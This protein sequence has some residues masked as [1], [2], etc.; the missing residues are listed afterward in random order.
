M[1][2]PKVDVAIIREQEKRR[3]ENARKERRDL[4]DEISAFMKQKADVCGLSIEEIMK[5]ESLKFCCTEAAALKARYDEEIQAVLDEVKAGNEMTDI[6][7]L[8]EKARAVKNKYE[9]E[10]LKA[11]ESFK[12]Y[13]DKAAVNSL[14]KGEA[15]KLS[16]AGKKKTAVLENE[17]PAAVLTSAAAVTSAAPVTADEL[18]VLFEAFHNEI[19][20]FKAGRSLTAV[21]NDALMLMEYDLKNVLD[22][23]LAP[24]KKKKK[25]AQYGEELQRKIEFIKRDTEEALDLYAEY[26]REC[27]DTAGE[28]KKFGDFSDKGEIKRE[29][30]AVKAKAEAALSKE[31]IRRQIDEVMAE[32][33]YDIIRSDVLSEAQA[34]NMILYGVNDDTAINVFVSEENNVTMRVV[35]VGFDTEMTESE[36]D[37]LFEQQCAFCKIHPQITEELKKR[38]VILETRKHNPPDRRF[39]TKLKV[40]RSASDRSSAG[41]KQRET[42]LK[43]MRKE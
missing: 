24:E 33:G 10:K 2:G 32:H 37:E 36:E 11:D 35:G 20:I 41:R 31:Y 6:T 30:S 15:E 26:I 23:D 28:P 18:N 39:N 29:I 21:H 8:K 19:V 5:D 40:R 7:S 34:R 25:I 38:G 17:A 22:G 1:S 27:F 16:K 12:A 14:L 43:A 13:V 42:G 9:R 4:A 3:L